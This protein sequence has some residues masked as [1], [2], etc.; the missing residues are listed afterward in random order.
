MFTDV[1]SDVCECQFPAL[2]PTMKM[3]P[4]LVISAEV[5]VTSA[6][7]C[8]V[9]CGTAKISQA[10]SSSVLT[11]KVK[12]IVIHFTDIADRTQVLTISH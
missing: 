12:K 2:C 4:P 9:K 7:I 3:L 1:V 10:E 11:G 6:D 8:K 5:K